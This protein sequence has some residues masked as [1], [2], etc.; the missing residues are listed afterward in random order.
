MTQIKNSVR[1]LF[2]S[3]LNIFLQTVSCYIGRF[4]FK[5]TFTYLG[6]IFE[7][8]LLLHLLLLLL[9]LLRLDRRKFEN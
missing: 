4:K 3:R 5:S 6:A 1:N 8:P 9:H 2:T 7:S